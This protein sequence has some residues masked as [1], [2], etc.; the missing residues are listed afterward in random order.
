MQPPGSRPGIRNFAI[1]PAIPPMMIHQSQLYDSNIPASPFSAFGPK[2]P[3]GFNP[4]LFHLPTR[5]GRSSAAVGRKAVA[6]I[7]SEGTLLPSV[8]YS[9]NTAA[10]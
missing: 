8:S 3:A 5:L 1:A 2:A 7:S 10:Q 4:L 9:R 6:K